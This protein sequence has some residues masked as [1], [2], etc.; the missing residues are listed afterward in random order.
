MKFTSKSF[1]GFADE[2]LGLYYLARVRVPKGHMN[3]SGDT[4][5]Y[6]GEWDG[7]MKKAA[8]LPFCI[9][10]LAVISSCG[11]RSHADLRWTE[12]VALQSGGT[13]QIRRHVELWH[14]RALG[15]GFS[16]AKQFKTSSIEFADGGGK[17]PIWDAPMVPIVLDKD[18][19]TNEWI[20]VAGSDG[21]DMWV[22]NGRPRPPYWAF[23]LRNGQWYRDAIPESFLG[24][25]A[26]LLVE[27]DVTDDSDEIDK[28]IAAR[29]LSQAQSPRHPQQYGSIEGAY[30]KGCD[31]APSQ[32][33]GHNEMDLKQFRTLP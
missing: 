33:V 21:C 4:A 2:K 14:H 30:E 22:R 6:G 23:R 28:Q 16:S 7:A 17:I 5:A 32:P 12:P 8:R 10:A 9:V 26:N 31:Q 19:A 3:K 25:S 11:L 27:F 20:V 1:G 13:V 15:G 18:P 29:K 24:R